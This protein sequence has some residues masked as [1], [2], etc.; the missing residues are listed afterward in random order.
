MKNTVDYDEMFG[1]NK[2]KNGGTSHEQ[3][4]PELDRFERDRLE[5]EA[6]QE[7]L[8]DFRRRPKRNEGF[9][10][11]SD[12]FADMRYGERPKTY[13]SRR[14]YNQLKMLD[15]IIEYIDG[16]VIGVLFGTLLWLLLKS[17][18]AVCIAFEVGFVAGVFLKLMVHDG[19]TFTAAK[20]SAIVPVIG[21]LIF[22][23]MVIVIFSVERS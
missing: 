16:I 23:V 10:A 15:D 22:V 13:Y 3:P 18:L 8:E 4:K 20:K 19:M 7:R 11:R 6:R 1:T 14:R 17:F 9:F 2:N 21:S 12:G 5:R